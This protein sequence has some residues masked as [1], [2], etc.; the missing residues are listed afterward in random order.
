LVV[1]SLED[2][3]AALPLF[4]DWN[5]AILAT[6]LAL[7]ARLGRAICLNANMADYWGRKNNEGQIDDNFKAK[8]TL[9]S[10]TI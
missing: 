5:L 6:W 1:G 10:T 9:E 8:T 7:F 2:A 4:D 3:G